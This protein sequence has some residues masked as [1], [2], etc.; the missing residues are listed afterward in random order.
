M[1][2]IYILGSLNMD[3][4]IYCNQYPKA[5]ETIRGSM[6]RTGAGGKGLNQGIAAAKLG[7][8]VRFLGA[9]GDDAFGKEM[10]SALAVAGADVRDVKER[11][12]YSSGVALITVCKGENRI[13]LDLGANETIK[14]EEIDDFLKYARE[15]DI[16]LTQGENNF[17]GLSY[18][19]KTAHA[20]KMFVILNPAPADVKM[21]DLLGS[22]DLLLPNEN[23]FAILEGSADYEKG[24]ESLKIPNL[25]VTLGKE[26][27]YVAT[28]ESAHKVEAPFVKVVDTTGAGDALAGSLA[29]FLSQG[30]EL[31]S[32]VE[33]AIAYASLSTTKRGTSVSM[34]SAREFEQFLAQK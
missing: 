17:D 31:S 16:F 11:K 14:D 21:K 29:Y 26:G 7:G 8:D 33:K 1:K 4:A 25:V 13:V 15:G 28:E 5:G 9:I 22:V 18:A 12:D 3:L 20:K 19:L 6:Y 34:P 23:E 10:K 32:S 24:R 27:A 30:E 2:R